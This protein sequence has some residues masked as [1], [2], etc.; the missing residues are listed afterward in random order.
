M[1]DSFRYRQIRIDRKAKEAEIKSAIMSEYDLEDWEVSVTASHKFLTDGYDYSVSFTQHRG[2][3]VD[4]SPNYSNLVNI[5]H[6]Q[7][8][9]VT[10]S[11]F[12]V[13]V[14]LRMAKLMQIAG[15]VIMSNLLNS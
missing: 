3:W 4:G 12:E 11:H 5:S 1:S 13:S 7:L 8:I 6:E 10:S 2:T 14:A 9:S 15:D